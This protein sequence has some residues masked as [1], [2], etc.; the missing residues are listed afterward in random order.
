[1]IAHDVM[2]ERS[3]RRSDGVVGSRRHTACRTWTIDLLVR[4]HE[5]G[6]AGAL[7]AVASLIHVLV[8][9]A[10]IAVPGTVSAGSVNAAL[11][12]G[13]LAGAAVT[14]AIATPTPWWAWGSRRRAALVTAGPLGVAC[15]AT[16]GLAGAVEAFTGRPCVAGWCGSAGLALIVLSL[17]P[18]PAVSSMITSALAIAVVALVPGEAP[19]AI[20][21][22]SAATWYDT[23]PPL[24]SVS[25][26]Y[27]LLVVGLG[28]VLCRGLVTGRTIQS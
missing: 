18:R 6:Q 9:G 3:H 11:L 14:F 19:G 2:G 28:S 24:G 26:P 8:G 1:M 23:A 22:L 10:A 13:L 25:T 5:V 4:A 15:L 16:L 20:L 17:V 27:A 21:G 12:A 7:L